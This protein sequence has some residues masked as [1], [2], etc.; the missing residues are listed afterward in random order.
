MELTHEK[1]HKIIDEAEIVHAGHETSGL[2]PSQEIAEEIEAILKTN[3]SAEDEKLFDLV[4]NLPEQ[5][6][7]ELL[8][9]M[10]IGRSDFQTYENALTYAKSHPDEFDTN[11]LIHK[12]PLAEYLREGLEHLEALEV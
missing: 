7:Y 2:K 12:G 11:Y 1:I 5:E 8:A 3:G 9:L 10:W 4:E 6:F